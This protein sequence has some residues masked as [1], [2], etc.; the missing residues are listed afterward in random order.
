MT[1]RGQ[2][3]EEDVKSV[4]MVRPRPVVESIEGEESEEKREESVD[5][6]HGLSKYLGQPGRANVLL[7]TVT[8]PLCHN[9]L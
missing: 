1:H 3:E 7:R 4:G 2:L 5:H 8:A 6:Q 9:C